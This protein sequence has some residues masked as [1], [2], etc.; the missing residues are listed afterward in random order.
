MDYAKSHSALIGELRVGEFIKFGEDIYRITD[1][2]NQYDNGVLIH[3]EPVSILIHNPLLS[4]RAH[5]ERRFQ[6]Y[7]KL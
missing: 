2:Y 6:V 4:V 1:V 5:R 3:F 7:R